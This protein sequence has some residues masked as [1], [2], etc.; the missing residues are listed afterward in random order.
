MEKREMSNNE[1]LYDVIIVGGGVAGIGAAIT[2]GSIEGKDIAEDFKVLLLDD[3]NSDL[4][5]AK[6]YNVP[7]VT[8]GSSGASVI[9]EMRSELNRFSIVTQKNLTVIKGGGEK[10]AFFVEAENGEKYKSRYLI[11]AT[12]FRKFE[13]TGLDIEVVPNEKAP[14]PGL[15]KA[16]CDKDGMVKEGLYIAGILSGIPS[17]YGCALGSGVAVAC[18]I[19]SDIKNR[20]II[21]HDYK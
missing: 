10:G 7:L 13:I 14:K 12:G 4:A 2:F 1:I 9:E 11:L 19:L 5:K 21:V 17:M 20:P 15:I 3:N 16:K 18:E 6:L 8:P